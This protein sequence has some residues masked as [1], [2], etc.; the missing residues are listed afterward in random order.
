AHKIMD[1]YPRRAPVN[2][3]PTSSLGKKEKHMIRFQRYAAVGIGILAMLLLLLAGVMGR[4]HAQA[5][6]PA[7]TG[8]WTLTGSM[9]LRLAGHTAALLN[10]GKV[11]VVGGSNNISG[12]LTNV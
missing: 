9:T 12:S 10:N 4:T 11:L 3:V 2:G 7:V 1:R 6:S 5:A 8:T